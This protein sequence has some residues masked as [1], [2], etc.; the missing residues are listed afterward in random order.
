M[1]GVYG[2]WSVALAVI[3]LGSTAVP[4][5]VAAPVDGIHN[6]QHVVVIMQENRS[7][8]QYFGT[9]PGANGIPAGICEP[10][11]LNRGCI[12]P[13]HD[14]S[15]Q[16]YGGPHGHNAFAADLD[17]GQARRLRRAGREGRQM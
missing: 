8:D 2:A 4:G 1:R 11:P 13:F 10:D 3:A 7:F 16:N 6:I 17:G 14:P 5:A 9:Y 12:T 15:D